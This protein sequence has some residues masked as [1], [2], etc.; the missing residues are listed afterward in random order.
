MAGIDPISAG[1]SGAQAAMGIIQTI[2]GNARANKAKAKRTAYQTPEE[3]FKLLNLSLSG[4]QGDTITRDYQ[5][6]QLDR[7]FSQILGNATRLGADPNDLSA[8][9]DQK[10]QGIIKVGDQFHAS[11]MEAMGKILSAYDIVASNKAAEWSSAQDI[12]KDEIQSATADKAA[13]I[14]NIGS[15]A[16]AFISLKSAADIAKLYGDKKV[17]T[18]PSL[19]D[20]SKK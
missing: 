2:S 8:L 19:T 9:F 15:A 3:I 16:N 12:L 18:N 13:G 6:G 11:N 20:S 14:Q 4:G 5:M 1:V 7:G 10:I 17:N